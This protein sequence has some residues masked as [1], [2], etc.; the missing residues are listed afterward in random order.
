MN[1]DSGMLHHSENENGIKI[2][3]SDTE[4][5]EITQGT[6]LLSFDINV[7]NDN[8]IQLSS[9]TVDDIIAFA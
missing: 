4:T 5:H 7:A 8:G 9:I 3:Y 1:L 2:V 6:L